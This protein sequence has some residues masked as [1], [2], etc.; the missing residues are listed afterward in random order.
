LWERAKIKRHSGNVCEML[1]GEMEQQKENMR[2]HGHNY[3]FPPE[4]L[5]CYE[6]KEDIHRWKDG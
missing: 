6:T 2:T 1:R 3:L 4:I 5:I